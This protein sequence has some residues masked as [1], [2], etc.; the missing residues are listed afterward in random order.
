MMRRRAPL[1][2]TL[3][4]VL[5]LQH[6]AALADAGP[7]PKVAPRTGPGPTAPDM[8]LKPPSTSSRPGCSS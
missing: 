5:G 4:A 7:P 2:I 1:L 6:T 8:D 3:P